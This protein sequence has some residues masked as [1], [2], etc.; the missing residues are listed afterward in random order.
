[1]LMCPVAADSL[2]QNLMGYLQN[3]FRLDSDPSEEVHEP[4]YGGGVLTAQ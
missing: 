2:E 3:L 1:M 4:V